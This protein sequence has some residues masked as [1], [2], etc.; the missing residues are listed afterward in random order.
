MGAVMHNDN[1]KESILQLRK[2]RSKLCSNQSDWK[3]AYEARD[4]V[5]SQLQVLHEMICDK[6][7][8]RQELEDKSAFILE[9]LS[10]L[11]IPQPEESDN[12]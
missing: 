11:P 5:V 8:K 6:K 10:V 3:K 12:A 1:M 2:L 9:K 7:I 4:F